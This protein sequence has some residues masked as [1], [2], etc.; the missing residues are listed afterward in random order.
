MPSAS[1]RNRPC[2]ATPL[3]ERGSAHGG[4]S[5]SDRRLSSTLVASRDC[6]LSGARLRSAVGASFGL[7]SKPPRTELRAGRSAYRAYLWRNVIR[8]RVRS[9]GD[10]STFTRS[11][12]STRM[13]KRRILP[14]IVASTECPLSSATRNMALGRTSEITPSISTMSCFATFPP[15]V[16]D[17]LTPRARAKRKRDPHESWQAPVAIRRCPREDARTSLTQSSWQGPE[18]PPRA[19]FDVTVVTFPRHPFASLIAANGGPALPRRALIALACLTML[20]CQ[21]NATGYVIAAS[22]P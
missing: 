16:R 18:T 13:R 7:T 21:Q 10:T 15:N 22:G 5:R 8:P 14:A 4:P 2:L 9:Y 1:R 19:R 6:G 12:V 3:A 20:A 17:S 11:P